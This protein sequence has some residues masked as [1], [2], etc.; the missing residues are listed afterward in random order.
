MATHGNAAEQDSRRV[1][2]GKNPRNGGM[3]AIDKNKIT[4]IVL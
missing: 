4:R 2:L 3:P 1:H